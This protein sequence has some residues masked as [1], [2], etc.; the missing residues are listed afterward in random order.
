L[1]LGSSD[2][3]AAEIHAPAT[4]GQ[5]L[6]GV[7]RREEILNAASALY[8][9]FG[10]SKTTTR[11]IATAV[12]I[13]QPSL[14]AHFPTKEAL[15]HALATRAFALLEAR[16]EGIEPDLIDPNQHLSA[17]IV[18]YIRFALEESASYKIAFMLDLAL[19]H[20]Q[21][22][23]LQNLVGL[24]AFS[25]FRDKVGDLQAQGFIQSGPTDLIAQSIWA[26]MHGLCALLLARPSFPWANQDELIAFHS[27]LIIQGA[28]GKR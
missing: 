2:P 23:I 28:R 17:L 12:G 3:I 22:V 26:A 27:G 19:D 24:R 9:D 7:D 16:M 6:K 25:I 8:I 15:S 11:Q 5:R 10:P 21:Q 18:G 14:Y 20:E 1:K 4:R 13:S